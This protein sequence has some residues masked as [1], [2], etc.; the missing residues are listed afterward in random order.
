MDRILVGLPFARAY[1]DDILVF[2]ITMEEHQ[3]H[4]QE[5]LQRLYSHGLNLHPE[6]CRFFF[7]EVE[8]LGHTIHPGGLGVQQTKVEAIT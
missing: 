8:Y 7:E 3:L 6:K 5:V 2:S 4:L 1:I